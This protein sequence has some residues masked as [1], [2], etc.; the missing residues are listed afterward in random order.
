M[1]PVI[2]VGSG[3]PLVLVPG[4][5]GRWEWTRPFVHALAC[6]FRV[7]SFTLAGGWSAREGFDRRLGFDTFLVQI[8]RIMETAGVANATVCGISYGGLVAMRYAALRPER[9]RQLVLISPLPPDYQPDSRY[10]FYARAPRL[11]FPLFCVDA[12]FR[13]SAEVRAAFPRWQDRLRFA[14]AQSLRVATAPASPARMR[15]RMELL[16][17]VGFVGDPA[18]VQARTLVV[19]GGAGLDRTVP[20][21][22]SLRYLHQLP[23]AGHAVLERTGHLGSVTRPQALADLVAGFVERT[24]ASAPGHSRQRVG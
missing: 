5:Q 12:A 20:A 17:T 22:L 4:I 10:R 11:L 18:R 2:D 16:S 23:Q 1:A 19:T 24:E 13:V 21:E 7:L 3:P 6:R 8:D 14:V 9:T 15:D